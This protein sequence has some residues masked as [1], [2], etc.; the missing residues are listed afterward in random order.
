MRKEGVHSVV[1]NVALFP[2]MAFEIAQDPRY[3]RFGCPGVGKKFDQYNLRVSVFECVLI[4]SPHG[5][6]VIYSQS[7]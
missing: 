7:C 6:A 3:V 1:L 5:C 4:M 2:G